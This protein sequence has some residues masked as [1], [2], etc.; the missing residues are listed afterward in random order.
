[1]FN[2]Q[3][4]SAAFNHELN[5]VRTDLPGGEL[6]TLPDGSFDEAGEGV[7]VVGQ[8]AELA[9]GTSGSVTADLTPGHYVLLC[10]VV[11]EGLSHYAQGMFV[12]VEVADTAAPSGSPV[13][14]A[15]LASPIPMPSPATSG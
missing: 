2:A 8:V 14:S 7:E 4:V 10:N 15:G 6:P 9:P 13:P 11:I 5:V 1:M 3:N 12:D